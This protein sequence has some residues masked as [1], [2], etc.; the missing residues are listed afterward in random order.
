MNTT[1]MAIAAYVAL[2]FA[3]GVWVGRRIAN[4][5]DYINAG[6]RIGLLVGAFSVFA[7]WFGAEAIV[8]AAGTVYE[9]GLTG[10]T[11]D[12]FGYATALVVAGLVMAR[13]L[14]QRG[15]ATFGDFFRD[16]YSVGVERL[17]VL[18]ILPGPI[19]WAA[20][21]IRAFG[22]VTSATGD[23][24]L[25]TG[26]LVAT[27][28][29]VAYTT[30]GGLLADAYTDV[31]QGAVI[32]LGLAIIFVLV[33]S[34]SG[35]IAASMAAIPSE[36]LSYSTGSSLGVFEM[37][38]QWAIPIGGTLVSIE[39]ISRMLG[40][41]SAETARQAC[42]VGGAIYLLVGLVPVYLGLVGPALVPGLENSEEVVS[43][44]AERYLPGVLFIV[45]TGAIVSAIL[46]TVDSALLASGAILS[47][48]ALE[49]IARDLG[50]RSR[51][52]LTRATVG[53]LGVSA[54]LI[55]LWSTSIHDLV[56]TASAF[57]SAGLVVTA[58]FG[59]FTRYGGPWSAAAALVTGASVWG[60]G[61][62]TGALSSPYLVALAAALSAYV[63]VARFEP[64]RPATEQGP[65]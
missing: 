50:E 42:I 30:V 56:E 33:A 38:E 36:R 61:A 46:S 26:I 5:H 45:F 13:P 25:A 65:S 10:A 18:L 2:Q 41:R 35:G 59:L 17:A 49:P 20:A 1:L 12:P 40:T 23:V 54:C 28:V 57:G 6:R 14:W 9:E 4:E 22:V 64:A 16:R 39:L 48:N 31:L 51:L 52:Y 37:I 58:L 62:L 55:A 32:I 53:V 43:R 29:I 34:E 3:I 24:S 15:Y 44:L 21:Q 27:A 8:G 60:L 47:R 19:I 63:A 11:I 7:T